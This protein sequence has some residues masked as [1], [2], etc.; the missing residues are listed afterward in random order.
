MPGHPYNDFVQFIKKRLLQKSEGSFAN[1][2]LG[3]LRGIIQWIFGA[4]LL[5]QKL[6]EQKRHMKL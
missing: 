4:L 2:F 5:G 1:E 6:R 3:E